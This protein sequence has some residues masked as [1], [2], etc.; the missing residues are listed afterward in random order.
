MTGNWAARGK[1]RVQAKVATRLR[2]AADSLRSELY[3]VLE[4]GR[5]GRGETYGD[6]TASA[7]G[8]PPARDTG[9]LMESVR[10][11]VD[12]QKLEAVVGPLEQGAT[13][14][15]PKVVPYAPLLE[16]GTRTMAPR[17]WFRVGVLAWAA[18]WR[19]KRGR[20]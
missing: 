5:V 3:G 9:H 17:P 6:H 15:N 16:Y 18:K 11:L 10:Y 13:I 2:V 1:A 8:D 19:A 12:E 20:P 14:R 4:A 7:P